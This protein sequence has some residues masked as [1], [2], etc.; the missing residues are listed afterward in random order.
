[1]HETR[2]GEMPALGEVPFGRYYGGVDTTP[3]FVA[4]AGAYQARTGDDKLIDELWPALEQA[5]HWIENDG[6]SD[7]DGLIDYA[8]GQDS[9]LSNQGWKD[10]EDSSSTPTAATR[11]DRSPWSRCRATPSPPIA[12][13]RA[14][15]SGGRD[16]PGRDLAAEGRHA[17][18]EGREAVLD[19]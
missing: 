2:K 8:R 9:G 7:G 4:L 1:M 14:W 3:L 16:R 15:P 19:G 6:D 5:M 13:W 10:S 17:A 12:A 18:R 11:P